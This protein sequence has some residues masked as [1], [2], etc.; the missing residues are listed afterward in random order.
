MKTCLVPGS[1]ESEKVKGQG[2]QGQK[3]HISPACVRLV[4][5]ETSLGLVISGLRRSF[6]RILPPTLRSWT[7]PDVSSQ[8]L[9][10]RLLVYPRVV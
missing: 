1:D 2:H 9:N 4:F 7:V 10:V 5:G 3:Q 8:A 6:V